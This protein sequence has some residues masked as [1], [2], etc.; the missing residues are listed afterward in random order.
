MDHHFLLLGLGPK[1]LGGTGTGPGP[2]PELVDPHCSPVSYLYARTVNKSV[3]LFL[4][5]RVCTKDIRETCT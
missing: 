3:L 5:F 2:S 1:V 4:R